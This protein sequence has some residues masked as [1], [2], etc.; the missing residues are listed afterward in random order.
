MK[1]FEVVVL[2]FFLSLS[3]VLSG[4]TSNPS[5]N[6]QTDDQTPQKTYD[7]LLIGQWRNPRTLEILDFTPDGIYS[8][9]EAEMEEWYTQPGG[10]LWMYGTQYT[11][12]FG[13]NNTML[14]ITEPGY[15]RTFQ[16]I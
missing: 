2:F 10:I 13:E 16:K 3:G 14:Y 11:Y 6:N 12:S 1:K 9:T 7:S 5:E 4:C 8:I 15:T